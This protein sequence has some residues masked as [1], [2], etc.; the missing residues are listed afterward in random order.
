MIF[1]DIYYAN[2]YQAVITG[3]IIAFAG[4]MME[5]L[6]LKRGTLWINNILD[7]GAAFAIIYVSQFFFPRAEITLIGAAIAAFLIAIIE[8]FLHTYLIKEGKI[9]KE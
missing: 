3:F 4:H 1:N 7:L 6:F 8:H 9:R 2:A 5:V